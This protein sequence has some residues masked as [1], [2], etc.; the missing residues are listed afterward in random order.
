[1]RGTRVFTRLHAGTR[2]AF[3]IRGTHMNPTIR[4]I[5]VP[6]DFSA[7]SGRV[8]DF[9]RTVAASVHAEVHLLHVLEQPFTTAAPYEF[10]LPDTPARRGTPVH[11]VTR[12]VVRH[13]R[14]TARRGR[15][16]D[17]RSPQRGCRGRD[18]QSRDRLRRRPDRD[19]H[20]GPPCAP[21]PV[22]WQRFR[23][24][25]SRAC[26]PVLLVRGHGAASVANAA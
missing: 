26:C 10:H 2:F 15:R 18:C 4:H 20:T 25:G 8:A 16:G 7:V 21:A 12:Q 6:V 19:G 11:A 24:R 9:A 23:K 5:L 13:R 3:H 14:R 22:E 17:H 1:M